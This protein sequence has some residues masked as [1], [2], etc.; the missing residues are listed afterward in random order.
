MRRQ[1]DIFKYQSNTDLVENKRSNAQ[2]HAR[3]RQPRTAVH[4]NAAG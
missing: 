4:K 2:R 1:R 3:L